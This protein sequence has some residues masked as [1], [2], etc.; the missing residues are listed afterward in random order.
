MLQAMH[1]KVK[2]RKRYLTMLALKEKHE[3]I[4]N[5]VEEQ[6]SVSLEGVATFDETRLLAKYGVPLVSSQEQ[7]LAEDDDS[8]AAFETLHEIDYEE[9]PEGIKEEDEAQAEVGL[10]E[11]EEILLPERDLTHVGDLDDDDLIFEE[12]L[13]YGLETNN[14]V[15]PPLS[16]LLKFK[17][18]LLVKIDSRLSILY[19]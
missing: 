1:I 16:L 2:R 17:L 5:E 14:G 7:L 10:E 11:L 4:F 13:M 19:H 9:E 3:K 18:L 12:N 8:D 6:V 15:S